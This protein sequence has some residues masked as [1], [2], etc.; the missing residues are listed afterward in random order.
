V[1][2]V[3]PATTTEPISS[4]N[5]EHGSRGSGLHF[6]QYI[7]MRVGRGP[8]QVQT[9]LWTAGSF[10]ARDNERR[11]MHNGLNTMKDTRRP[12]PGRTNPSRSKRWT[13]RGGTPN[14][15]RPQSN[16]TQGARRNYERYI[17]LA[18]AEVQAGNTIGAENFYQYAEHYYRTMSRSDEDAT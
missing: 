14:P 1:L 11:A 6:E 3:D 15:P 5:R 13:P 16:D 7:G 17:A 9:A 12:N 8:G 4:R 18:Q 2:S 10:F